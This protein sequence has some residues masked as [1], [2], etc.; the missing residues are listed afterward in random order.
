MYVLLVVTQRRRGSARKFVVKES[1][2]LGIIQGPVNGQ[3]KHPRQWHIN[4]VHS[5]P[6][7]FRRLV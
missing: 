3:G 6:I 4:G 5:G 2:P 1:V 7:A